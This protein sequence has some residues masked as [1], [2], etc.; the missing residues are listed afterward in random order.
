MSVTLE[1]TDEITKEEWVARGREI[2]LAAEGSTWDLADWAAYGDQKWGA[3]KEF[4]SLNGY[5]YGTLKLYSF[6]AQNVGKLSRLN[7]LSFGHHAEVAC[8]E[9]R[10]QKKW[11]TQALESRWSTAELRRQIRESKGAKNALI[12]DG[13]TSRTVGTK[14]DDVSAYLLHQP[15]T[16]D[17]WDTWRTRIEPI[18]RRLWPERF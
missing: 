18:A 2:Y 10:E 5:N 9:D 15:D 6:V 16:W 11:L 12:P 8:F 7:Q 14:W 17:C 13:P 4:C 3:L 1:L